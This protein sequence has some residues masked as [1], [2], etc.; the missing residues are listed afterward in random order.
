MPPFVGALHYK[1]YTLYHHHWHQYVC[2]EYWFLWDSPLIRWCPTRF[3]IHEMEITDEQRKR[4]EANRLAA[5]AKRKGT[6]TVTTAQEPWKLFKCRKISGSS[7][8]DL[9][10]PKPQPAHFPE[11][12]RVKL[13]IC[14]PDSFSATPEA[15]EGFEYPGEAVCLQKLYDC[16]SDVKFI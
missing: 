10:F 16:L 11:N 12:F 7:S 1:K 3:S 15:V 6:L 13:E 14:S 8:T 4:A 9:N 5:L 2:F